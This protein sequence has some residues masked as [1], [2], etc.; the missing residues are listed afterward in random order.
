MTSRLRQVL[1]GSA[2]QQYVYGYPHKT[3]YA[4][5]PAP[6][7]LE[8]VWAN[9]R[10]DSRFL[11]VHV[12]FCEMRCGFCNLFTTV[13][14]AESLVERFLGQLEVEARATNAALGPVTWTRAAIGGGTPTFLEAPQL[15]RLLGLMRSLGA[16]LGAM[17]LSVELSPSTV[18]AEKLHV[19][20]VATRLSL[21]VQSFVESENRSLARP[22]ANAD[23]FRTLDLIRARSSAQLNLDLIYGMEGQSPSSFLGSLETALRWR[24]EEL[25]LYPLYVRPLTFLGKRAA[26]WDDHRRELYRVARDW[27]LGHGYRQR[28]MRVFQRSDAPT[29]SVPEYH[30]E[31]DGMVGLGV[32]ARSYTRS[33]HYAH[34]W[35]VAP[36]AVRD[37]IDGYLSRPPDSFHAAHHGFELTV[38]EQQRRWVL[39]SLFDEGVD[40]SAFARRFGTSL[41]DAMPWLDELEAESLARW[42]GEL[43]CLTPVGLELTDAIGPWLFSDDVAAKMRAWEAR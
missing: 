14:P 9:E 43:L 7:P 30:P 39:L 26:A 12:P 4:R 33:L 42:H 17:P 29:P 37:I 36:R 18:S 2:Y 22:Q 27:L 11:Y 25:Y 41:A 21:G 40:R 3:A 10:R 5:F 34:D 35:A 16:P 15:E 8:Q 20:S 32:G 13:N 38:E 23:V 6:R 31:D 24:P 28:S 1:S 19:L